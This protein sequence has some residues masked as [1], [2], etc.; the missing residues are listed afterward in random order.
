[1]ANNQSNFFK[2]LQVAY[3]MSF[4]KENQGIANQ[5]QVFPGEKDQETGKIKPLEMPSDIKKLWTWFLHN[6]ADTADSFKNRMERYA[7][8]DY[9]FYNDTV[10]SS[11]IELYADETV[12]F[13]AQSQP[14]TVNAKDKKVVSYI[15]DFFDK[16]GINQQSLR[17]TA[18][19]LALYGDSFLINSVKEGIGITDSVMVDVTTIKDRIEFNAVQV[20]KQMN[21]YRGF[22]AFL[23]REHRLKHLSDVL[24]DVKDKSDAAQYYKSYLFGYQVEDDLFLAPWCVTHFRLMSSKSE[25]YPYGRPLL[26]NS[27]SSFRQLKASKN[28]MAMARA[29]KFPKEKFSI[30][31]DSNMPEADQWNKINEAKT[32]YQ[33]LS[34]NQGSR[35]DFAVGGSIWVP[36]DLV[37]YELLINNINL[38]DIADIELLRDDMIMGSRIPKDYLIP[39]RGGSWGTSGQALLQQYKPFGRSVL[40][41]QQAILRELIQMV[42]CQFILSGDYPEDT[43]FELLMHFPVVEDSKDRLSVKTDTLNL[44]K[45]I[46]DNLTTALG[47]NSKLPTD[48]IKDIFTKFTFLDSSDIE[49]WVKKIS[50][51]NEKL[52]EETNKKLGKISEDLVKEA[53]FKSKKKLNLQEGLSSNKHYMNS[54]YSDKDGQ[55]ILELLKYKPEERKKRV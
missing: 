26:I 29:A 2:R 14:L 5:Y 44:A 42:K 9:C 19:N 34:Y 54:Y 25:F 35:E 13:D 55:A 21:Q 12:Q 20:K 11:A 38:D 3:G 43:E 51:E 7:D 46:I 53:Y 10:I 37:D 24:N 16:I 47:I 8:M 22:S 30:K 49:S 15:N 27:V 41:V 33:N 50:D 32:E 31:T 40:Q 39:S 23:S 45:D 6:T 1:M 52:S 17:E 28:L 18:R 36:K 48:V 4:K